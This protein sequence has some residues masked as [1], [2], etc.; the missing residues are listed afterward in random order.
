MN[1]HDPIARP[2]STSSTLRLHTNQTLAIPLP[3]NAHLVATEGAVQLSFLDPTLDWLGEAV[4]VTR[5]KLHEGD[6]YVMERSCCVTVSGESSAVASVNIQIATAVPV[7]KWFRTWFA[8]RTLL[9][10]AG[11]ALR[12]AR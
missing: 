7:V 4:P 8:R 9:S 11:A 2:G 6:S 1:K 5:L 3:R 10:R 12:K